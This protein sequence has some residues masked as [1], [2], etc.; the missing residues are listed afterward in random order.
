M[1]PMGHVAVAYL[2]L[3]TYDRFRSTDL[4]IDGPTVLILV[5]GSLFPD[6]V[7]KPLAW[8]LGVLPTGR[9]LGHSLLFLLPLCLVVAIIARNRN[10]IAWAIAFAI[11]VITHVFL[12]ALPILWDSTASADFLLY[13][14][15][16]VEPYEDDTAPGVIELF[17]NSLYDPYFLVE[18]PLL[19]IALYVW[20][21]RGFPGIKTLLNRFGRASNS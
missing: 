5:F 14:L 17:V 12:D 6:I 15:I 16:A 4:S 1:W 3:V 11:G 13:P 8:Y 9:S 2:C 19:A 7:D 20:Y 10:R 18:F 21:R